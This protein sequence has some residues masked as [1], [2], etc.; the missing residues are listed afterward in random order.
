MG[1]R[2]RYIRWRRST[3]STSQTDAP[4]S[5][6]TKKPADSELSIQDSM[7]MIN[8]WDVSGTYSTSVQDVSGMSV[9]ERVD[10]LK[11]KLLGLLKRFNHLFDLFQDERSF[12]RN[13]L[14]KIDELKYL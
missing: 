1:R 8:S 10:H 12:S 7:K 11:K 3:D 2:S 5:N 14:D 9:Q 6:K 4:T 13:Y